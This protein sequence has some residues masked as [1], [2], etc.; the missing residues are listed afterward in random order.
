LQHTLITLDS[1]SSSAMIISNA[2]KNP[3]PPQKPLFVT[4]GLGKLATPSVL[5]VTGEQYA[6]PAGH[7]ACV[8]TKLW[9]ASISA[10]TPSALNWFSSLPLTRLPPPDGEMTLMSSAFVDVS[11]ASTLRLNW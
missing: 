4:L 1:G 6:A 2:N 9:T 10:Y 3:T 11:G 8:A 5:T 7:A